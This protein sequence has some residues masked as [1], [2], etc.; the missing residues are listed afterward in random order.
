MEPTRILAIRHGETAWN[1]DT[2]LQGHLDIP[3]NEVGLRQAQHLAKALVQGD[4][5]DAI[6]ASDLSRAHTTALAIAQR[7]AQLHGG[8]LQPLAAPD[9]GAD[10]AA[11]PGSPARSTAARS[12]AA[13]TA[14]AAAPQKQS[15][16]AMLEQCP[17]SSSVQGQRCRRQMCERA[18]VN[19]R[20]CARH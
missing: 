15:L 16:A 1:V 14:P 2:R 4:A 12:P 20:R 10:P 7:V 11:S 18:G 19:P 5:I 17:T 8:S 9:G 13:G 3:L 6:Y